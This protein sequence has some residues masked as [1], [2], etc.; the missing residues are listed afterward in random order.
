MSASA[1]LRL[2]STR[3]IASATEGEAM[4]LQR[5]FCASLVIVALVCATGLAKGDPHDWNNVVA[6]AR[7]T[8]V[9]VKLKTGY[10]FTGRVTDVTG[11]TITLD[12]DL[13]NTAVPTSTGFTRTIARDEIKEVRGPKGS[14][15]TSGLIGAGIGAGV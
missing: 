7:D 1:A 8:S 11:S 5:R 15:L 3:C 6:L 13:N 4:S 14:R 9:V 2:P 10:V 12:L